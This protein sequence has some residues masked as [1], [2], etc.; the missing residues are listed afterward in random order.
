[1]TC[2]ASYRYK[3]RK[4]T[5]LVSIAHDTSIVFVFSICI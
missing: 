3:S 2:I 5:I 4:A 1:M